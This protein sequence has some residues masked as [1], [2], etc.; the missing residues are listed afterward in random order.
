MTLHRGSLTHCTEIMIMIM[1]I[2]IVTHVLFTA[3]VSIVV[4]ISSFCVVA[5]SADVSSQ[6][7]GGRVGLVRTHEKNAVY[8]VN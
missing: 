8:H 3:C 4:F 7:T 2:I 5:V 1:I 6:S